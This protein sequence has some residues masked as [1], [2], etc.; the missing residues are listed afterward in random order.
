MNTFLVY[1]IYGKEA[2]YEALHKAQQWVDALWF[3][4]AI[5]NIQKKLDVLGQSAL[6]LQTK[7]WIGVD[8]DTDISTF[9]GKVILLNFFRWS[10]GASNASI[11]QLK[12]IR[13]RFDS[14]DFV[15]IGVTDYQGQ[16]EHEKSIS[17][18]REYELMRD[19]YRVQRKVD[20]PIGMT[21]TGMKDYGIDRTPTYLLI[22]R[23]GLVRECDA[24][25]SYSYLTARIKTLVDAT[26]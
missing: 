24:N 12:T 21:E 26:N 7:H 16:Y 6:S 4:D 20:W 13:E 23:N 15:I 5:K 11:P 22:D 17:K 25:I 3:N 10:C 18:T 19:H 2:A 14:E 1:R 9:R 8:G